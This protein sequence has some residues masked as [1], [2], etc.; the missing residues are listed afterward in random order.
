[1]TRDRCG[2]TSA[3]GLLRDSLAWLD[4][5]ALVMVPTRCRNPGTS[6]IFSK[7]FEAQRETTSGGRLILLSLASCTG[8]RPLRIVV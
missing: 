7:I 1:M 5:F 2:D 4:R 6:E 3:R 8:L